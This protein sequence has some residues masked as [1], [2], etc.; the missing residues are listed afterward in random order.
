M[1]LDP[2][3]R[4]AVI[5]YSAAEMI[6]G[7]LLMAISTLETLLEK[8]PNYPPAMGRLAAAY[9]VA[10]RKEEGLR[11]LD[12][13]K[14]RGFDCAGALTEQAQSFI[15]E[16]KVESAAL[17]LESAIESGTAN[18]RSNALLAECR[19]RLADGARLSN[20]VAFQNHLTGPTTESTTHAATV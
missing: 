10:G 1:E 15:A 19:T 18:G 2:H 14:A 17:L 5:N 16:N 11:S 20:P 8:N 7:D 6:A 4:E 12:A 13:L 3:L 9:L